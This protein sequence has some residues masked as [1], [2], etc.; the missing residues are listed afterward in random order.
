[1]GFSFKQRGE[2]GNWCL[3]FRVYGMIIPEM[4]IY[5]PFDQAKIE[6]IVNKKTG[7]TYWKF[8]NF[9]GDWQM[10]FK[11]M[12]KVMADMKKEGLNAAVREA[13]AS[14]KNIQRRSSRPILLT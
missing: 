1:M 6:I 9:K 10:I 13:E 12:E 4:L 8:D 5:S 7:D 11:V 2:R 14:I 3:G